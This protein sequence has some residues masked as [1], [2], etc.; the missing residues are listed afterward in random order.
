M[1]EQSIAV[2]RLLLCRIVSLTQFGSDWTQHGG[3][4]LRIWLEI[5]TKVR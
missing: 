2:L 5:L 1:Y 4:I 3:G